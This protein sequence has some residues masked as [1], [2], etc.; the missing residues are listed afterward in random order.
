MKRLFGFSIKKY[1]PED[2]GHHSWEFTMR[3]WRFAWYAGLDFEPRKTGK[4]QLEEMGI[5]FNEV[6]DFE[7][8]D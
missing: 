3:V 5:D 6:E 4:Q 8:E 7:D 2:F 1:N